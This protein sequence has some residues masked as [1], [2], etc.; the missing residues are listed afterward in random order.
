M[1]EVDTKRRAAGLL[2]LA[3]GVLL[4]VGSMMPWITARTGFGSISVTGL[5]GGGD[6]VIVLIAGVLIA[7]AGGA[8]LLSLNVPSIV[9]VF[10]LLLG[11]GA[12]LLAFIDHADIRE[13]IE[14]VSND[15]AV[16][17]VGA[18]IWLLYVGAIIAA[19]AGFILIN[20]D[21]GRGEAPESP[22]ER[23]RRWAETLA[24]HER[25]SGTKTE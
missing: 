11:L 14:E 12:V 7:L 18:G 13:R 6:G 10:V 15:F 25:E 23:E 19:T 24:E 3:G 16:A 21:D 4:I 9:R 1:N 20:L 17:Q 8:E 5:D 2:A 22:E